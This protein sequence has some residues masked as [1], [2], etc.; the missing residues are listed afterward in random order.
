MSSSAGVWALLLLFSC[1]ASCV[2]GVGRIEPED[3]RRTFEALTGASFRFGDVGPEIEEFA[4]RLTVADVSPQ[5]ADW[6][7]MVLARA[8]RKYPLGSF[9]CVRLDTLMLVSELDSSEAGEGGFAVRSRGLIVVATW[10]WQSE[11]ADYFLE[12][13]FHHEV[14]HLIEDEFDA[15]A[16]LDTEWR[17]LNAGVGYGA[18]AKAFWRDGDGL[19]DAT[20]SIPGF[21]SQ[22][23]TVSE[24]EDKA[25]LFS[26]LMSDP[27]HAATRAGRDLL[28]RDKTRILL[29]K[30][31]AWCPAFELMPTG[32]PDR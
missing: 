30:L 7:G 21:L 17:N 18:P 14:F 4:P 25:E 13:A 24:L 6:A 26:F 5:A 10:D 12:R 19:V 2:Q 16:D 15:F 20:D 1:L 9:D 27:L 11:R 8:A 29:K 28:V 23:G 3:G 32:V 22:Y 31:R